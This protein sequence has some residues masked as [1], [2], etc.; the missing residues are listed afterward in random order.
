MTREAEPGTPTRERS[1]QRHQLRRQRRLPR[2]TLWRSLC[3]TGGGNTSPENHGSYPDEWPMTIP[4]IGWAQKTPLSRLRGE[5]MRRRHRRVSPEAE[6]RIQNLPGVTLWRSLPEHS[7]P[8]PA[9]Q[10][11]DR[12]SA[13]DGAETSVTTLQSSGLG[14]LLLQ[15]VNEGL[16]EKGKP[17]C[18][19][20][21]TTTSCLPHGSFNGHRGAWIQDGMLA[22][23]V[24]SRMRDKNLNLWMIERTRASLQDAA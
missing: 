4:V 17:Q 22:L 10:K 12:A 11:R 7:S 15:R 23:K 8:H 16:H 5:A 13:P 6:L 24:V 19:G 2:E 18:A 20:S 1:L 9:S 14:D 3:Q 21:H